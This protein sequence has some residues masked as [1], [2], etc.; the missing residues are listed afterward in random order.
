[1]N[2]ALEEAF[3]RTGAP[4]D[5][6]QPVKIGRDRFGKSFPVEWKIDSGPFRGAE[7]NIDDPTLVPTSQGP[8][9]PHVGYQG[10]GKRT[11][12]GRVRGHIILDR[13][14]VT[15]GRLGGP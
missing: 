1:M 6:F 7:V 11:S 9:D 12:G 10:P 14:P 4:R 15:R 3:A 13:V 2:R 5:L 8:A